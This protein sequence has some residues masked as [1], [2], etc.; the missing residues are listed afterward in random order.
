MDKA[1]VE[2]C[3]VDCIHFEEGSDKMLF[4]DPAECIDCGACQPACPV[5]AIFPEDDV[6]GDQAAFTDI[7]SLWFS[8]PVA[9]RAQVGGGAAPAADTENVT[10]DAPAAED[11]VAEDA[12]A[13]D[14][15]AE[16]P[17]AT[18][19]VAAEPEVVVVGRTIQDATLTGVSAARPAQL[20]PASVVM[21]GLF[22]GS[23]FLMLVKPGP[24]LIHIAWAKPIFDLLRIENEQG[25]GLTVAA[26]LPLA[27]LFLLLFATLQGRQLGDFAAK[28]DRKFNRWRQQETEWRR[29][30]ESRKYNLAE[31]VHAIAKDRFNF[32]SDDDP[33][34]QSYINCPDPSFGIEPRGTGEK[35]FPDIVTV[36]QPGNYPVAIAQ[37]ESR[38]T[39][40][41]EQADYVWALY[42]NQDCPLYIYVPAGLLAQAKDYA[43]AANIK[44]IKFRTWRWS[45]NGMVVKEL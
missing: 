13:E 31:I 40:T 19:E 26:L 21:L 16:A 29:S 10:A 1:C 18:E 30:E 9:A 22:V 5:S 27:G 11:A 8:D 41:R 28:T 2:V 35:V 15:V 6:P 39:V 42:Q 33:D 14:A 17:A 37:I 32:P 12:V 20:S 24:T 36:M 43:R 4:I 45:P 23:V 34:L 7:N 44:N 25:V 3:P 38:E